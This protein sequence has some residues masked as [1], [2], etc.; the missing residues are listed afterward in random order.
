MARPDNPRFHGF[1]PIDKPAGLTSHDIVGRVRR[2]TRQRTVGH[3]GTLDPAATGVLT[4]ALGMATRVLPF[5]ADSSKT[6]R[7][8]ITFGIETDTLDADGVVVR[9]TD[10]DVSLPDIETV[11][12]SWIG[13]QAQI[14]PKY[15]ALQV[16][17][18]RLYELARSG[19]EFEAPV[20]EVEFFE[21]TVIGFAPPV[22][23]LCVD[24]GS[25]TYIRSLARD[26]GD[27][28]GV[29]AYLSD[30]VRLRSGAFTLDDCW[31]LDQLSEMPL[32]EVWPSIAY[33]PDVM[34]THLPA[35]ILD[36]TGLARW[37]RGQ[38]IES[39]E[40]MPVGLMRVYTTSGEWIGI[41][42]IESGSERSI[43]PR[44]VIEPA[45]DETSL[46]TR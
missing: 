14:A 31:T 6:Y 29:A 25:G 30:L 26:L 13:T 43:Q 34:L 12:A 4:V 7:A 32:E 24:C 22:L 2:L 38:R 40:T 19:I 5:A 23:A 28:L 20:R 21:L 1:L 33:H 11:L 46:V 3:A 17:G 37:R 36:E 39:A 18:R 16:G 15:S 9:Q 42:D 35:A 27:A 10:A 45:S 41:G 44:R 8:E